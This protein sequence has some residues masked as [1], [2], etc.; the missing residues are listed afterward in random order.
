[1]SLRGFIV[2]L[3]WKLLLGGIDINPSQAPDNVDQR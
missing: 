3:F 2:K 1:M